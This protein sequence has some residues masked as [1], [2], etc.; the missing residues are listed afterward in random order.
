VASEIIQVARLSTEE[1]RHLNEWATDVFGTAHLG[2]T[3]RPKD[4]HFLLYEDGRL[5]SHVGVLKHTVSAAGRAV[6]VCGLGGVVTLAGFQRRGFA[7]QLMERAAEGD[8]EAGL[9]FCLPRMVDYYSRLGWRMVE[10][11]VGIDQPGGRVVSPLHVMVLPCGR[12]AGAISA[13]ELG[14]FP[15]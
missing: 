6:R 15:W 10:S 8:L 9:L 1:Y 11:P 7:R 3:F 2:L 5:A 12:A 14:S 13:V 4:H